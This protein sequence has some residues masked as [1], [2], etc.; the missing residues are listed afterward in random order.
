MYLMSKKKSQKTSDEY[1]HKHKS[2][3]Y[4]TNERCFA[5]DRFLIWKQNIL[6][7]FLITEA[8]NCR[9]HQPQSVGGCYSWIFKSFISN[10]WPLQCATPKKY[11]EWKTK[12]T[13][14]RNAKR[15]WYDF[16]SKKPGK[17]SLTRQP[18]FVAEWGGSLV[19]DKKCLQKITFGGAVFE[20]F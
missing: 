8:L 9:M 17:P 11:F 16:L 2:Y 7:F 19:L 14:F 15:T 6:L 18:N 10:L 20:M 13:A 4:T 12:N 3:Y 5:L 1:I